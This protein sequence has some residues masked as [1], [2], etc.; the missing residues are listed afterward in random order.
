MSLY[1]AVFDGPVAAQIEAELGSSSLVAD[2]YRLS[3][4]VLLISS[5][6]SAPGVLSGAIEMSDGRVGVVFKL[7]GSY[8]GHFYT[9]LW[10]WLSENRDE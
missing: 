10:D 9:S 5:P 4:S 1:V 3:E 8:Q 7:N 2:T 6:S